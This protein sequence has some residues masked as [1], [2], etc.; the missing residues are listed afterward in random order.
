MLPFCCWRRSSILDFAT[1]VQ[2]TEKR[3]KVVRVSDRALQLGKQ[4]DLGEID[5][6]GDNQR[7]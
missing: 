2:T 4:Q 6:A 3:E 7:V 5:D 1:I